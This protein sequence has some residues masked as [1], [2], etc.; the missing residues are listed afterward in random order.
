MYNLW[1]GGYS[2]MF[3]RNELS[4]SSALDPEDKDT[5]YDPSE[6]HEIPNNTV[7]HPRRLW[8]LMPKTIQQQIRSTVAGNKIVSWTSIDPFQSDFSANRVLPSSYLLWAGKRLVDYL[9][10]KVRTTW[11][12]VS[13]RLLQRSGRTDAKKS[14]GRHPTSERNEKIMMSDKV[15]RRI[16][17][18]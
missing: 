3:W 12:K 16:G 8:L 5:H 10:A 4:S 14:V 2:L 7:S 1:L 15:R 13:D 11:G 17:K 18:G 6:C 9:L